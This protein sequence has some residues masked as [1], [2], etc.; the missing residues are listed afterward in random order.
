MIILFAL[1]FIAATLQ[2]DGMITNS[3]SRLLTAMIALA[4]LACL[5][6]VST[7]VW[8]EIFPTSVRATGVSGPLS[9]A[10]V[11]SAARL[12]T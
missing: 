4:V 10:R 8:A 9:L 7:A 3:F 6:G 11:S 12:P 1:G 5:F 2:L